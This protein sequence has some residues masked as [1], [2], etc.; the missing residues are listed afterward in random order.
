MCRIGF[1]TRV[2]L[3]LACLAAGAAR[4]E[5]PEVAAASLRGTED[6]LVLDADFAFELTPRL[7]EVVASGVPLYFNVEFE[8]GRRR[9]Y[10]LDEKAAAKTLQLRLSYHPLSRQYRLASGPL[11]QT[12]SSLEEALGVL[13]RLRGWLV[14]ERNVSFTDAD[15]Q[16]AVRFRLDTTLLPK[17][18]QVS[19]LTARD[20]HLETPWKRFTVRSPG[21]LFP[22]LETRPAKPVE[23]K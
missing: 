7:A 1:L 11:Q 3:M 19:A 22:P 2:V 12:Y 15:Y 21:R 23:E 18:F 17:P 14:V 4:A 8:L 16:A 5:E 20:L 9:W 10:W 13:R 6:G